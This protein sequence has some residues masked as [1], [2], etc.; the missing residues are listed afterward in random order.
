M[1]RGPFPHPTPRQGENG[2]SPRQYTPHY[3]KREG[4]AVSL[5]C[6]SPTKALYPTRQISR[7]SQS[8]HGVRPAGAIRRQSYRTI[9][10][11]F[12]FS[13]GEPER[14]EVI[15]ADNTGSPAMFTSERTVSLFVVRVSLSVP[16]VIQ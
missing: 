12:R 16:V 7:Q 15:F 2:N 11:L 3:K 13:P 10:R 1:L 14:L 6:Q 9:F 8:R 4:K 5:Q